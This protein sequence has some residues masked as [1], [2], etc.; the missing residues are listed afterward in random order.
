[1][2][3]SAGSTDFGAVHAKW[4]RSRVERV[5]RCTELG[6]SKPGSAWCTRSTPER[7]RELTAR[8]ERCTS[9]RWRLSPMAVLG[10]Q[11]RNR[12]RLGRHFDPAHR[13]SAARA[14]FE[15]CLENS[16]QQPAPPRAPSWRLQGIGRNTRCSSSR[17]IV[18][19][20]IERQLIPQSRRRS[21][22]PRERLSLRTD[23]LAVFAV[24]SKDAVVLDQVLP[25]WGHGSCQSNQQLERGEQHRSRAVFPRILQG[26]L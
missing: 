12:R 4:G 9:L 24:R 23:L 25:R 5:D 26:K 15:V 17:R 19:E 1:L 3:S 10:K 16:F 14:S 21:E 8:H 6:S 7:Q 13:A 11:S 18:E 22:P 20:R 2:T